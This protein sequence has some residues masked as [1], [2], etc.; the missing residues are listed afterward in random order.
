MDLPIKKS[1]FSPSKNRPFR[2]IES[3][4]IQALG[5]K[6]LSAGKLTK[7]EPLPSARTPWVF[8]TSSRVREKKRLP[9]FVHPGS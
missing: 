8:S 9:L 4:R 5:A 3:P 6:A 1:P 2:V 7:R